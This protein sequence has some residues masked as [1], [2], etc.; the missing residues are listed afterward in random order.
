MQL[1]GISLFKK[2]L[3]FPYKLN[4]YALNKALENFEIL[5]DN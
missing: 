4:S 1:Y 5:K 2:E 3:S